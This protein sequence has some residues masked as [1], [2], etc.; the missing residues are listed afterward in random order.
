MQETKARVPGENT[1]WEV[2]NARTVLL[3]FP[4][5][6]ACLFWY[7]AVRRIAPLCTALWNC[8][9]RVEL[10]HAAEELLDDVQTWCLSYKICTGV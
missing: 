8:S 5:V 9:A 7:T 2:N 10:L 1:S 6:R 3:V 4:G